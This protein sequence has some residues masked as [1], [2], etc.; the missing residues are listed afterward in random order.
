MAA[1]ASKA[2]PRVW[3]ALDASGAHEVED[4]EELFAYVST[5]V[6]QTESVRKHPIVDVVDHV[7][8]Y[9]RNWLLVI[10]RTGPYRPSAMRRLLDAFD[11][12]HPISQRMLTLNLR[13]LERDGFISREVIEDE[14]LHVEYSLTELGRELSDRV[15][16][17]VKWIDDHAEAIVRARARFDENV[18]SNEQNP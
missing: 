6:S 4:Q 1:G 13:V 16:S 5:L 9:W 17:L 2:L 12:E 7:G 15:M 18:G 3:A 11:P 14:R 8:N 10:L